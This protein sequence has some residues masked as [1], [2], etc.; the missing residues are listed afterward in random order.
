MWGLAGGLA[1]LLIVQV[2]AVRELL[3]AFILFDIAC[4]AIA[5][6]V[7]AVCMLDWF[8]EKIVLSFQHAGHACATWIHAHLA[9]EVSGHGLS[10]PHRFSQIA[11]AMSRIRHHSARG[12]SL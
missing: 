11:P 4:A 2:Y 6:V 1:T 5:L 9:T 8:T 3:A 10:L 7:F 12:G